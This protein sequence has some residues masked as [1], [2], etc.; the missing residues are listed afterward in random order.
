MMTH[1]TSPMAGFRVAFAVAATALL[2]ACSGGGPKGDAARGETLY[3]QCAGCHKAQENFT[4]PMHCGLVGRKA[5]S[6]PDFPYSEAMRSSGLTWDVKTLDEFLTSP[7]SYV[8]GTM[9]GF[10]G[11]HDA[12]D[13]ADLIAYL[14]RVGS[15]PAICPPK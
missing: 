8:P 1:K 13:R 3:A 7:I 12:Q 11:F 14:Q 10:V 9:M 2:A 15:D 4:G 6:V 5:A